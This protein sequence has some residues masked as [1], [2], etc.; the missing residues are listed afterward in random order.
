MIDDSG[1]SLLVP[2]CIGSSQHINQYPALIAG[3]S[4]DGPIE[5]AHTCISGSCHAITSQHDVAH[6]Q[7]ERNLVG[8]HPVWLVHLGPPMIADGSQSLTARVLQS[9]P[10][11]SLQNWLSAGRVGLVLLAPLG[12]LGSTCTNNQSLPPSLRDD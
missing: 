1:T 5:R 4:G 12:A 11:G 2:R 9:L 7:F 10:A 6:C 8:I 3:V